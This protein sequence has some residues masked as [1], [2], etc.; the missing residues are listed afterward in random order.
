MVRRSIDE[1]ITTL[2]PRAAR[3]HRQISQNSRHG[4]V[5]IGSHWTV[6]GWGLEV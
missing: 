3:G 5:A 6:G 4:S 2:V 1:N